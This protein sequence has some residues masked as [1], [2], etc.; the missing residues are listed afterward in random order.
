MPKSFDK[1]RLRNTIKKMRRIPYDR[2]DPYNIAT[3]LLE[4]LEFLAM[5]SG[6]KPVVLIGRGFVDPEWINGVKRIAEEMRLYVIQGPQWEAEP[7][8]TGLPDWYACAEKEKISEKSVLYICKSPSILRSLTRICNSGEISVEEESSLLGYPRCCVQD[9]YFRNRMM[10]EGFRLVL[11][12]LANGDEVEM[13]R[14]VKEDIAMALETEEEIKCITEAR[15]V[16]VAPYTSI[17]MCRNCEQNPDS[18]ARSISRKFK[19]FAE[20]VDRALAFDIAYYERSFPLTGG[21]E[22]S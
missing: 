18:P 13:M 10:N 21:R 1:P 15:R 4:T 6:L 19:A 3:A 7:E 12:R 5:M 16:V 11:D 9:H 22:R 14:L 2:K 8:F 20:S 17:V